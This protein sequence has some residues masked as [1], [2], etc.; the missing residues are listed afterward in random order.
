MRKVT[1]V[2]PS[3]VIQDELNSKKA[4]LDNSGISKAAVI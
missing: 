4:K 3:C 1:R 2:T